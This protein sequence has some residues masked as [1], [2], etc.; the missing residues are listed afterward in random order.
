MFGFW[1]LFFVFF[2]LYK[3]ARG[4]SHYLLENSSE[5]CKACISALHRHI[6]YGQLCFLELKDLGLAERAKTFFIF[7]NG[8]APIA[9]FEI[10]NGNYGNLNHNSLQSKHFNGN[11]GVC[12]KNLYVGIANGA[13]TLAIGEVGDVVFLT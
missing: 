11:F 8:V 3:L 13:H 1:N 12:N 2:P 7:G 5:V 9:L 6:A 10:T 4:T